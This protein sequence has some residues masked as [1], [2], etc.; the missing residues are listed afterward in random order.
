MYK[1]NT[2]IHYSI[3]V[4]FLILIYLTT[5]PPLSKLPLKLYA[6]ENTLS[7]TYTNPVGT[8]E[9]P[10]RMGDPF[11]I[12]HK[13]RYYLYASAGGSEFN[14]WTSIDLV[15]WTFL[16][17]SR[18]KMKTPGE[19]GISGRSRYFCLFTRESSPPSVLKD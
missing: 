15:H 12:K 2:S 8:A 5:I 19:I 3:I 7:T 14:C 13:D 6:R 4:S 11:A 18:K 17:P 10:I 16:G 1:P 9:G